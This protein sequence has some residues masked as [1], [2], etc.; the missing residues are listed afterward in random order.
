[1][2]KTKKAGMGSGKEF[3]REEKRAVKE[4]RS[5]KDQPMKPKPG[6]MK[7]KK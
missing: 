1:M 3:K 2:G 7:K 6:M 5:S 4:D